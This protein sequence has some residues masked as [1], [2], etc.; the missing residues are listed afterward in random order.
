MRLTE[1]SPA[2][3]SGCF[4]AKPGSRHVDFDVAW[5]GPTV[6]EGIAAGDGEIT[7]TVAVTI[8]DLILCEDC[9]RAAAALIGL[10]DQEQLAAQVS[11]LEDGNRNLT[12]RVRGLEDHNKKLV[13][14]LD[15]KPESGRRT[16]RQKV[17]A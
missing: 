5:D 4:Q 8:D 12:E 2:Y 6:A 16:S 9:L 17:A 1:T 3:C 7:Q 11:Q 14:A 10:A 15:S 13:D